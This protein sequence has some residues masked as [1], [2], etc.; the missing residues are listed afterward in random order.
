[1]ARW[2]VDTG[3]SD[4]FRSFAIA[5]EDS[6]GNTVLERSGLTWAEAEKL[7]RKQR[8]ADAERS[9]AD[10]ARRGAANLERWRRRV[11]EEAEK[12]A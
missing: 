4:R 3:A 12:G 11:A 10:T 9:K 5:R 7:V 8:Q 1:M 2:V 6:N